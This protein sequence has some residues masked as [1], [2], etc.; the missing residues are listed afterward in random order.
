MPQLLF[1]KT[2]TKKTFKH[3]PYSMAEWLRESRNDQAAWRVNHES[4]ITVKK[5]VQSKK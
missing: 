4:A 5:A 3:V 2:K 1:G